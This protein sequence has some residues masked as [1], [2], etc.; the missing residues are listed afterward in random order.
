M[1]EHGAEAPLFHVYSNTSYPN[2]KRGLVDRGLV[3]NQAWSSRIT[4]GGGK[5]EGHRT[6]D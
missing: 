6:T 3:E 4:M 2:N 1:P 5:S